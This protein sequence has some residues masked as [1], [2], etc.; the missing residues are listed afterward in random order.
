MQG[1][2]GSKLERYL[3]LCLTPLVHVG[4]AGRGVEVVDFRENLSVSRA[5]N[6]SSPMDSYRDAYS[7]LG[8]RPTR[9]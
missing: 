7:F 3:R 5:N 4:K 9:S 2:G 6:F 8:H 1:Y